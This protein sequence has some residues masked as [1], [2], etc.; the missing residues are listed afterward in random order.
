M[1]PMVLPPSSAEEEPAE[2]NRK[3]PVTS[4]CPGGHGLKHFN[5]PDDGWWCS[6]CERGH[7]K[8]SEFFGC[9]KCDYDECASCARAPVKQKE[10]MENKKKKKEETEKKKV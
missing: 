3:L 1:A 5:T 9:R 8:A 10:M 7:K 2:E 4:N 6:V